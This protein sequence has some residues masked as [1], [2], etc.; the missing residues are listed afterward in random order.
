MNLAMYHSLIRKS[1]LSILVK[2]QDPMSE[3]Y[4]IFK[5][6]YSPSASINIKVLDAIAKFDRIVITGQAKSHCVMESVIQMLD[7]YKNDTKTIKKIFILEDTMSII[8]SF[9]DTTN[10]AFDDFRNRSV[11][12]VTTKDFSL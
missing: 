7:Y 4:G 6:E 5:P 12:L 2:G 11:N 3:M 10:K 1:R 8:P 9:E